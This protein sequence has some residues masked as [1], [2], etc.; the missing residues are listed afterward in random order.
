LAPI[1]DGYATD[2]NDRGPVRSLVAVFRDRHEAERVAGDLRASGIRGD[3]I[4]IGDERDSAASIRSEMRDELDHSTGAE[5][6]GWFA[7][8]LGAVIGAVIGLPFAFI[9]MGDLA[10]WGR[11][12][13]TCGIGALAGAAV[14]FVA[15]GS[16]AL[17][18]PADQVAAQR[19]VTL[20][21]EDDVD[22]A[23]VIILARRPL[24]LDL[25]EAGQLPVEPLATDDDRQPLDRLEHNVR[26]DD[27]RRETG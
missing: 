1:P 24:R 4:R 20:A 18:G 3:A 16:L 7:V 6:A 8:V 15:G 12:L 19:G 17:G 13:V 22:R 2:V 25:V 5:R 21:V 26:A 9:P 14:G 11:V 10:W 23:R 27:Y